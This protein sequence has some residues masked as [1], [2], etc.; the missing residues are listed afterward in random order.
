MRI[1][2]YIFEL[3]R[4]KLY[5]VNTGYCFMKYWG[6]ILE[7]GFHQY[8]KS[9]R[10]SPLPLEV[11]NGIKIPAAGSTVL[12]VL[13]TGSGIWLVRESEREDFVETAFENK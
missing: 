10:C 7:L 1:A 9:L 5:I 13:G 3:R 6:P 4:K 11:K 8:I 2:F 12:D